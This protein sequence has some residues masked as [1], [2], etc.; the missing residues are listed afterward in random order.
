M[1]VE[2]IRSSEQEPAKCKFVAMLES[3]WSQGKFVCVGLDTD[4]SRITNYVRQLYGW[5]N[6]IVRFNISI[7]EKT[8]PF[9]CAFKPNSAFYEAVGVDGIEALC[10]TVDY[11]KTAHPDIPV[12]LDAKRADIGNTNNGYVKSAF[13][14]IRVDAITVHPFL[15]KEAMKPFLQRKDKGILVLART[16][17]PGAGEFQDRRDLETGEP[18]YLLV[19]KN[20]AT[21][22][23]EYGNCGLV[24]GATYP[25]ELAQIRAIA[26]NMPILIPGVGAQG[27]DVEATVK[28]GRD[29][30]GWGMIIN[31]SRGILY[32]SKGPDFAE[33]ASKAAQD[34]N[35]SILRALE[36]A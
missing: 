23:N 34:L 6:G 7:I 9:V 29:S 1:S 31:S 27:G 19:A 5:N 17:N 28:A 8:A 24:V 36:A 4:P 18:L 11:I 14:L 22:W 25:T 15:G 20:V 3:R 12:I 30:R 21:Q 10:Q 32:A 26:G 2:Q 33:A 16:S 13:D 35:N